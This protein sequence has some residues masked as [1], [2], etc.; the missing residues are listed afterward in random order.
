MVDHSKK[1]PLL[2]HDVL[3]ADLFKAMFLKLVQFG[4]GERERDTP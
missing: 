4:G 2:I 3:K 1:S